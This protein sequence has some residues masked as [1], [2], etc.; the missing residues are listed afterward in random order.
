[1]FHAQNSEVLDD[2]ESLVTSANLPLYYE[3]SGNSALS[4]RLAQCLLLP[5][6]VV[7]V[8]GF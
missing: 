7:G 8:C 5:S 6:C 2:I 4:P 1:M 3:I